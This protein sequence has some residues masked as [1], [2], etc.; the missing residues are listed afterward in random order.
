MVKKLVKHGNSLA[1]VIERPILKL[2][3]LDGSCDLE[4]TLENKT[5]C[6]K[7]AKNNFEDIVK[8]VTEEYRV[9]LERLSKS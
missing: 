4:V 6:I 1:F 7:R 8:E 9:A 2:M 5:L 3:D